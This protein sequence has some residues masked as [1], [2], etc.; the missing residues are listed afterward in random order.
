MRQRKWGA[1]MLLVVLLT[2]GTTA[3]SCDAQRRAGTKR[4]PP[5]AP[6]TPPPTP[7]T[8]ETPVQTNDA[9]KE[10]A[11][12]AYGSL[13]QPFVSVARDAAWQKSVRP[14]RITAGEL[15][16]FGGF[17]G[18]QE[19]SRLEGT[20]GIMRAGELATLLC[21][22]RSVGGERERHMSDAATGRVDANGHITL[23]RLD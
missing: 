7:H 1:C 13:H 11:A 16:V 12:G 14:Y 18:I 10:L 8:G 9:L 2:G 19:R 4:V 23:P 20:L 22:V 17:A 3:G 21:D 15:L 6:A 5:P